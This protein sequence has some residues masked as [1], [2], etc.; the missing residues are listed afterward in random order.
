M[1]NAQYLELQ[2]KK[3]WLTTVHRLAFHN[4]YLEIIKDK[5]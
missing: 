1:E 3:V 2:K 5:D 4:H